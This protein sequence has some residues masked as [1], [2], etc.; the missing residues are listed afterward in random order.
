MT[1]EIV[2]LR[3]FRKA[4][5]KAEAQARA[6]ENRAKHGRPKSERQSKR[7]RESLEDRKLQGHRRDAR[8][9][10]GDDEPAA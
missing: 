9:R 6:A 4:K 1:A 2:N 5:E 10:G 3:R 7:A 8:D